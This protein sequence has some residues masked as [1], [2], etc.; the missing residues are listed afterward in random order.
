MKGLIFMRRM[1]LKKLVVVIAIAMIG[2]FGVGAQ[3]DGAADDNS[4]IEGKFDV[5]GLELYMRC[6]G[7]GSP[8]IVYLH[9]HIRV[10]TI[11]GAWNSRPI[12]RQMKETHRFCAYDRRNVGLSD[13]VEGYW[14]GRT[15]AED[16]HTLLDVA[17]V[18]PPYVL[19]GASFGGVLSHIYAG[20]YPDEVVGMVLLDAS[21]PNEIELDGLLD[22]EYRL[23][24]GDEIGSNEELDLFS[25]FHEALALQAPDIPLIY[26]H[27][28]PT[29]WKYV[30]PEWDEAILPT[31][32]AYVDTFDPGIWV[33]VKSSHSMEEDVPDAIIEQLYNLMDIIEACSQAADDDPCTYP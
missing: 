24:Y 8:T 12:Q 26:M 16:L 25:A 1:S 29:G 28:T 30:D 32:Q 19:L 13:D 4:Q 6:E 33:D 20:M 7:T 21:V 2:M 23:K 10:S 27:A 18:A 15:A 14:T 9:G 17:G 3:D 5:G 31:I 22:P 11:S